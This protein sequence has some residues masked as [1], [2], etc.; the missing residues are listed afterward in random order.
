MGALARYRSV[1]TLPGAPAPVAASILGSLPI[2]MFALAILLLGERETGSFAQAGRIAG[3]F[4]LAN[5]IGAVMQGRLMDRL[6]QTRVLRPAATVHLV[7]V[8]SLVGLAET[9]RLHR[10]HGR[11]RGG[12]R[13]DTPAGSRPRCARCGA[14]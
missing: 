4:G 9:R 12:G 10:R 2:G 7:A 14:I 1:L 3:A 5:A 13:P 11:R 6:G 8:A